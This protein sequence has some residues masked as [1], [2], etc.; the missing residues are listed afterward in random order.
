MSEEHST[1]RLGLV[2]SLL[3]VI[4]YNNARKIKDVAILRLLN[5]ITSMMVNQW[6]NGY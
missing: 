5:V 2:N 4:S 6:K 3:N 1:L